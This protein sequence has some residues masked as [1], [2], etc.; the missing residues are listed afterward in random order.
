[1]L[2]DRTHLIEKAALVYP[3]VDFVAAQRS[4]YALDLPPMAKACDVSEV[5]ASLRARRS[6]ASG[7]CA[8]ALHKVRRI[9]ERWATMYERNVHA[10]PITQLLFRDCARSRSTKR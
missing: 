4:D 3:T 2:W 10:G 6:F 8:E 5:A 7:I 1:M 9:G